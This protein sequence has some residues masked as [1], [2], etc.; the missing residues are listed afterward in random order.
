MKGN[1]SS[2]WMLAAT[3]VLAS[4][5]SVGSQFMPLPADAPDGLSYPD[6]NMFTQG[7]TITPLV[8]TLSSGTATNYMVTPD[9]PAG[10]KLGFDGKISGTP[11]EPRAP[12]TYLVTAGNAVGTASFGVRI[13]VL[14]R[15]TIGGTVS[16]LTGTGL[17][18]TNNG[19]DDLAVDANGTFTFHTAL[20][21]GAAY[22]VAVATQPGGQTC[23]VSEG[24]GFLT[25][26]NYGRV[27]VVCS[28]NGAKLARSTSTLGDRLA[29]LRLAAPTRVLFVA[30][31]GRPSPA[32]IRGY[33]VDHETNLVTPLGEPVSRFALAAGSS[34]P[35]PCDP[36]AIVADPAERF[37][38]VTDAATGTVTVYANSAGPID[39]V[40]VQ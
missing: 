14:G 25:N 32:S 23:S 21:A 17:V 31:F 28:A 15:F 38:Y 22:S 12:A 1:I 18:L 9:L 19:S 35:A 26:D 40:I 30:C 37:V 5:G 6:P 3:V 16:G 27:M 20:G 13:T 10:L 36:D 4:C 24:S 2:V 8:P 33:V 29:A 11:T 34:L 7:V 39:Q